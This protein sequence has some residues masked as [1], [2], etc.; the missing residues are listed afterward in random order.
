MSLLLWIQCVFGLVQVPPPLPPR[1]TM[2]FNSGASVSTNSYRRKM[3]APGNLT[4]LMV[5]SAV[6]TESSQG[7]LHTNFLL[8]IL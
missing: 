4:N 5:P 6:K 3:S 2:K 7:I 1:P 8:C